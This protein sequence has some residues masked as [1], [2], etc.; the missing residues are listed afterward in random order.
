LTEVLEQ[1]CG[2]S[3]KSLMQQFSYQKLHP[4]S[5]GVDGATGSTSASSSDSSSNS[6]SKSAKK[7][8]TL[9]EQQQRR[10]DLTAPNRE[11]LQS[12]GM[13]GVPCVRYGD[14][15]VWGQDKLWVIERAMKRDYDNDELERYRQILT[16]QF[17]ASASS[18]SSAMGGA[19]AVATGAACTGTGTGDGAGTG[20]GTGGSEAAGAVAAARSAAALV[21]EQVQRRVEEAAAAMHDA[22]EEVEWEAIRR[23]CTIPAP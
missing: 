11:F 9:H 10:L 7:L 17:A 20:T 21:Q 15:L 16:E 13:W 22:Q 14:I 12:Q 18:S 4:G 1:G 8:Y 3:A 5:P 2:I 6:N 23:H 19:A